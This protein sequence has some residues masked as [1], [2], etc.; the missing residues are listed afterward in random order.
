MAPS[1][2]DAAAPQQASK[3]YPICNK[4]KKRMQSR[5]ARGKFVKTLLFWLPL[6]RYKCN[7]CNHKRYVLSSAD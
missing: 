6:K 5:V 7:S 4:C 1:L 3:G 2:P